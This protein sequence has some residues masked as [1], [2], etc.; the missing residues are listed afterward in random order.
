MPTFTLKDAEGVEHTYDVTK[1]LTENGAQ[2]AA[3]VTG[4]SFEALALAFGDVG[5][6][7][8][9]KMAQNKK[10]ANL[11][12]IAAAIASNPEIMAQLDAAKVG[13]AVRGVLIKLS[14][15]MQLQIL[16]TT[17]RDSKPLVE[18]GK[19]T[20]TYNTAYPAN[21]A[22]LG[23]AL[24]KVCQVNGFFPALGALSDAGKAA[25]AAMP[26]TTGNDD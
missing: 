16:R 23:Q 22:E 1:H 18:E 21:Y 9:E 4:H 26:S 13:A 14:V 24:V 2:L 7:A 11:A 19:P 3:W 10:G 15:P 20:H 17:N 5:I 12:A 8:I 25:I 6:A